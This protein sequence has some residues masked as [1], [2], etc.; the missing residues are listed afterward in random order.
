LLHDVEHLREENRQLWQALEDTID[1]PEAKPQRFAVTAA[2][3]GV[4]DRQITV[5]LALLLAARAP[6]RATVGRWVQRRAHQAGRLRQAPDACCGSLVQTVCLDE[7]FC[8]RQPVPVGVEPHRFACV[9]ARRTPDRSGATWAQVLKPRSQLRRVVCD[10]GSGL[11][12]GLEC[13]QQQRAEAGPPPP[14]VFCFSRNWN[15]ASV[16]VSCSWLMVRSRLL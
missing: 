15:L 7:I 5:L 14:L 16:R 4:S 6:S 10:A 3:L 13:Y 1:F 11:R 9:L 12:K 8:R 2:A